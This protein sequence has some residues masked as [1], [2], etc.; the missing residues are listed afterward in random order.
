MR[1]GAGE[2]LAFFESIS[3]R[4]GPVSSF[5]VLGQRQY[6][7]DDAELISHILVRDQH[8]FVRDS[9]AVLLRELLG[10]GL[11]TTEDPL[12]LAR[13]RLMQ[14]AFH[15]TRVTAY[16]ATMVE[17][18]RRAAESWRDGDVLDVGDAMAAL[19]LTIVGK[20]LF[21]ADV[22]DSVRTVRDVLDALLD[23]GGKLLPLAA[24]VS[25]LLGVARRVLP[26]RRSL[27]FPRE[28]AR[29][30][31][32]IDPIVAKR[33]AQGAGGDDL[34]SLLLESRDE[35]GGSLDDDALR[36]ELLTLILAGHETTANALTWV[37]YALSR[38]PGAQTRL[39]AELDAV[40]GGRVPTVGDV[41]N[42]PFTAS[43][44]NEAL[45][46]YPPAGAFARRP[47]EPVELG[48]YTIP[49]MAS[50]F[51]SPYVTQRNPRY[52]TNAASF[53]PERWED[54]QW[55]KFAYFPFGGG[56][57]MCIGEPFARMEAV[58]VIAALAQR[59]Q[60]HAIDTKPV[61]IEARGALRP[62]RAIRL[63]VALREGTRSC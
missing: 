62:S 39:H 9:G 51:V 6:L 60:F 53:E 38:D 37:W 29:L 31:S 27:M 5:T 56:S 59:L 2:L 28:R 1:A 7:V 4:Y 48:G 16:G 22:S 42:L 18:S 54:P 35:D 40:L 20:A 49:R 36:D 26:R 3:R 47:V 57:K 45:R 23:R 46:L 32:V 58:L 11:L 17:E 50:I 63:R 25:P 34:L 15:R 8:R 41:A 14:P 13:R 44:F 55:P 21:G 12:H 24:F 33:R 10:P 52:F 30:E 43:V 61:G 19:T